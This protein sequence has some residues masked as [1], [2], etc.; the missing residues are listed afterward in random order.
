MLVKKIWGPRKFAV[1]KNVGSKK[2][3]IQINLSPNKILEKKMSQNI[4]GPKNVL[5]NKNLSSE[6]YGSNLGQKNLEHKKI[7]VQ[8][9]SKLANKY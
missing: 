2:Y 6:E 7:G 3:W 9:W 4:F 1:K 5:K 8:V